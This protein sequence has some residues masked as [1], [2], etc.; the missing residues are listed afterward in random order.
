MEGL[1]PTGDPNPFNKQTRTRGEVRASPAV[2]HLLVQAIS[3][4]PTV[5]VADLCLYESGPLAAEEFIS[6]LPPNSPE[7]REDPAT[8]TG[9]SRVSLG[10]SS[11]QTVA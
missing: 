3:Q 7:N 4:R 2:Y 9:S 10:W 1:A 11:I 8:M 5:G 6:E